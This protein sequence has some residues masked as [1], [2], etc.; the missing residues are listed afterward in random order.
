MIRTGATLLRSEEWLKA[1]PI[2]HVK[3]K[4][5]PKTCSDTVL[6]EEGYRLITSRFHEPRQKD[7]VFFAATGLTWKPVIPLTAAVLYRRGRT[8]KDSKRC[9]TPMAPEGRLTEI[10]INA[11]DFNS[12]L[13]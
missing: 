13:I 12:E 1:Y 10:Y 5:A 4:H 2:P 7:R 9:R 11:P 8:Q 3:H 6:Q